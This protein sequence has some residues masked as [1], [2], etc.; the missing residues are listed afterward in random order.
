[1]SR[2]I[3]LIRF[4]DGTIVRGCYNGTSDFLSQ[5]LITDEELQKKY[6]GSCFSWDEIMYKNFDEKFIDS[7]SLTDLEEVEVYSDYGSGFLWKDKASKS[8]MSMQYAT[9]IDSVVSIKDIPNWVIEYFKNKGWS[10]KHL[11]R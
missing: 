11:I 7:D 3:A 4:K 8:R 10:Y 9:N 1:M 5:W 6:N 2:A